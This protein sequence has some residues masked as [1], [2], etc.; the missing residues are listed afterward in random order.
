MTNKKQIWIDAIDRFKLDVKTEGVPVVWDPEFLSVCQKNGLNITPANFYSPIPNIA[1]MQ[2]H[3]VENNLKQ[4]YNHPSVFNA[5]FIDEYFSNL[6]VYR[7]ELLEPGTPECDER[8]KLAT[9]GMFSH[10]DA[11][12][13]YCIVRHLQPQ[14]IVEI[15]SGYSTLFASL[16]SNKNETSSAITSYEPYP[17]DMLKAQRDITLIERK[18]QDITAEELNTTLSDG[19]I[20]FIDS[21]HTV[22]EGSD[23][24]H[25][26]TRLLPFIEKKVFVH[27]H[28]IFLPFVF[29]QHKVEKMQFWEEQY[30]LYAFLLNNPKAKVLF[31]SAYNSKN[32]SEKMSQFTISEMPG[33][34]SLWFQYN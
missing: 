28:D 4:I 32:L 29:P 24:I 20:L 34:G 9:N 11:M 5:E 17:S 13:Y 30:L 19:D 16:A 7:N 27:F 21:T 2:Q 1:E 26:I 8:E 31:G 22:N 3:Y 25:I 10:S 6:N 15:G 12:A 33:G 23:V 18:A 14:Q